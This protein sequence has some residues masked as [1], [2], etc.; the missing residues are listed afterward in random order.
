MSIFQKV[1]GR[2]VS[3]KSIAKEF[4]TKI[5]RVSELTDVKSR[6]E[7]ELRRWCIDILKSALGYKDDEIKTELKVL[8][9]RVDIALIDVNK[10]FMIIECKAACVN[11]NNDA[12]NQAASYAIGLGAEWAVTTNGH[13]WR[14]YHVSPTIGVEPDVIEIFNVYLLDEDGISSN[15]AYF[16]S[17][18]T[19]NSISSGETIKQFHQINSV[20]CERILSALKSDDIIEKIC[21]KIESDYRKKMGTSVNVDR[22]YL[23]DVLEIVFEELVIERI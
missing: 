23:I 1:M 7:E 15:D 12:R 13:N 19:K 21:K 11:L 9:K 22:E 18:L 16:L 5:S 14:L 2:K 6:N 4:K 8:G 17:L 10:V 3:S 20:S